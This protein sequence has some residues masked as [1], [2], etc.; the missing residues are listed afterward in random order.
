MVKLKEVIE[1]IGNYIY[2]KYLYKQNDLI[3]Q[4]EKY[5]ARY[6]NPHEYAWLQKSKP[7]CIIILLKV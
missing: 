1:K 3:K 5:E 7:S 2:H 4:S 6:N